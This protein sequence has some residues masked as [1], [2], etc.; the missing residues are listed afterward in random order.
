MKISEIKDGMSLKYEALTLTSKKQEPYTLVGMFMELPKRFK[1]D[2]NKYYQSRGKFI[3]Y[4]KG[5]GQLQELKVRFYNSDE[6]VAK[7]LEIS[8]Q[9]GELPMNINRLSATRMPK[10]ISD[11]LK[12]LHK[13]YQG[14]KKRQA[15]IKSL[16]DQSNKAN[17]TINTLTKKIAND[18]K[19]EV[20]TDYKTIPEST[21]YDTARNMFS[22]Y[23]NQNDFC[24]VFVKKGEKIA[25]TIEFYLKGS[26]PDYLL[27][28]PRKVDKIHEIDFNLSNKKV[29]KLLKVN[30]RE[31]VNA[32]NADL[33]KIKGL[34]YVLNYN[35]DRDVNYRDKVS[36]YYTLTIN[37]RV[38]H[39]HLEE[40][41]KKLAIIFQYK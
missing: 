32:I 26:Y 16:E 41:V 25:L 6:E 39:Q 19:K 5:S 30:D 31:K 10:V 2:D 24:D 18:L 37:E 21:F 28:L 34:T 20:K 14:E 22:K 40:L 7:E 11:H 9:F 38:D 33:N 12:N 29:Y 4:I 3:G 17:E 23:N 35:E 15:T 1:A 36:A 8:L 13:Q 27:N